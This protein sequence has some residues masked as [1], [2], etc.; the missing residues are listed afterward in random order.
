MSARPTAFL[1][2]AAL[3]V[4]GLWAGPAQAQPAAAP[5]VA[6]A[7]PAGTGVARGYWLA[8]ASGA[9][10]PYGIAGFRGSLATAPNKPIVG[11]ATTPSGNGYWLAASDGGIFA[12]G[13][14]F[15]GSTGGI[16]LNLPVVGIAASPS[17]SGY[18]LVASDGGI[19]A[20]GVPFRGSTGS[21]RLNQPIV[22]MAPT[23]SGNG[24]WLVASDGG[25]FAFGDAGFYG[26]MGGHHLN[27]PIVAMAPTPSG[28]GYWLTASDGGI[29]AFGDA[30]F[31]GSTGSIAL[32]RPIVGMA[33]APSGNGYWLTASDGGIFAF[34]PAATFFGS[35][36]GSPLPAPVVGMAAAPRLGRGLVGIFYYPW[37][38]APP[39][40]A[41]WRHWD[42]GG[43]SPPM[44]IGSNYYPAGG[45]YSSNDAAVLDRQMSEIAGTGANQ[46]IVSWWGQ[47]SWEDLALPSVTHFAAAHGLQVAVHLEPYGGRSAASVASD[48]TYLTGRGYSVFYAYEA[49]TITAPS[50]AGIRAAFPGVI[51]FANGGAS[52]L[53]SG[54]FDAFAA[55]G[56]FDGV[57]TYDPYNFSGPEFPT[58][59]A[60]AEAY[61]LVCAPSVAPGYIATRATGDT[62]V[63][64]R[65]GGATYDAMWQ[66]ALGA[67][68]GM[69]TITSYNEWHEGSQIEPDQD[70]TDPL[71]GFTYQSY[72][73][74]YGAPPQTAPGVYLTR[75]AFWIGRYQAQ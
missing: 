58:V 4:A 6:A 64:P 23:P 19:F 28:R 68:P 62:R 33:A 3:L 63:K 20:F 44:D 72:D 39:T 37:Y 57:Y 11:I 29:F 2:A 54:S 49:D 46:V 50:W 47:G 42:E 34:G 67:N 52:A 40:D 13:L 1:A 43:H 32:A 9:V 36:G 35:A 12:F 38:G 16:R 8:T 55:A 14:P 7:P 41:V 15:V 75:T 56:G 25:I 51:L 17:G 70:F 27:R 24:Y 30:R 65:N 45:P 31:F 5:R 60:D 10:L 48:L 69:I 61:G 26:S 73:Y 59:C 71:D 21:I 53:K 18:W 74:D 22:G 66:G